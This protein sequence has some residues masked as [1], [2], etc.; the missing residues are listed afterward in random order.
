[1]QPPPY[2]RIAEELRDEIRN[3]RYPVGQQL[4]TQ[5]SLVKRFDV[6]RATVQRALDELRQGG[7]IDSQQ[8]R[9]SYVLRR[10]EGRVPPVRQQEPA[11]AGVSLG[12]HIAAAFEADHVTLDA[13]TLTTETLNQ[14]VQPSLMR[15][16][17]G[18]LR[19]QSITVRVL[20]P[21]L[22]A[23]LALPRNA[24]DPADQRPLARLH[25]L[26][27]AH[28]VSF[29]SSIRALA[30]KD[31]KLVPEV[32]IERRAVAVTPLQKTYLLNGTEALT[33]YYRVVKRDEWFGD[34]QVSIYDVLGLEAKLFHHSSGN[35]EGGP[36]S[37][38]FVKE[39]AQ[40]FESL[41]STIAEPLRLFE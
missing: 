28:A 2:R 41:W 4:P 3:G 23:V 5:Q 15:I 29:E 14:A 22:E 18:E 36:M 37:A 11:E 9:G 12:E 10:S 38:A 39:T 34:E 16:R 7:Y 35:V 21:S 33:G 6:S 17:A 8:G 19:P 20:L 24:N 27:K 30:R 26:V 25:E 31:R 40:W 1:M 13:F 32:N